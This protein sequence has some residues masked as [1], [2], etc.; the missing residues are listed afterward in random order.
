MKA[1]TAF[2]E[3]S[4]GRGDPWEFDPGPPRNRSWPRLFAET[5]N[6]RGLGI[7]ASGDEEFRWHQGPMFYR[8][9]LRDNRVKV[10]IIGQEGAQDESLS[11]RSFTGGTGARMQN[12]LNHLGIT[13]S[14]LFLNTFVYPIFGQYNGVLPKLAQHPDSP[15]ARHRTEILDYVVARNDLQLVIAVGKA[16]KESVASWIESHGGT[17]DPDELELADASVISP[18]LR[19]LGVLHPGGAAR[20]GAVSK[21]ITDFK[22]AIGQVETW[23]DVEPDWLPADADGTRRPADEYKYR[24]AAIPFRDFAF[25]TP[26]RLGRGG[27]SSNRRDSQEAIQIFGA[28]G[29]YNERSGLSY[30][31]SYGD[32]QQAY[33]GAAGDRPWEPPRDRSR[34]YDRGPRASMARLLMGGNSRFPLPDFAAHGLAGHPSFGHGTVYRGRLNRPS[35]LV[36][37]DQHSHDDLFTGRALTGEAGQHLQAWLRAAG[38]TEDYGIIR[39]FPVDATSTPPAA[40]R[41]ALADPTVH[42]WYGEVIRRVRPQLVLTLGPNSASLMT[43]IDSGPP[44]RA[45]LTEYGGPG[46]ERSWQDALSLLS[47]MSYPSDVDATFT[48]GGE[49]EQIARID[50][51]F[52]TLGWQAAS[53]QRGQQARFERKPSADYFKVRM[54]SWVAD[55]DSPPLTSSE[56]QALNRVLS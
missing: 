15:I 21:I 40:V 53:G 29:D 10:L 50:L 8:G 39:V 16:A 7:A 18:N 52:G 34:D 41:A 17:A 35:V 14:Y 44:A 28:D 46:W 26:W 51:P 37:A 36:V 43:N 1:G 49:S 6:Y 9:R 55:L 32:D 20:G 54:P 48:Y 42:A 38:L 56:Q 47:S 5:P 23:I 30:P 12:V 11:H 3:Y 31:H 24:S 4:S 33:S 25:G 13:R 45:A 19:A 22:A 2:D 27:T